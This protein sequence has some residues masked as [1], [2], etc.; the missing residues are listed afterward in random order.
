MRTAD[1]KSMANKDLNM[2]LYNTLKPEFLYV[3]LVLMAEWLRGRITPFFVDII[4]FC[5]AANAEELFDNFI[6]KLISGDEN[7]LD[8]IARISRD[9]EIIETVQ[10]K[11]EYYISMAMNFKDDRVFS[12]DEYQIIIEKIEASRN[13]WLDVVSS[14]K[15]EPEDNFVNGKY[16]PKPK[17]GIRSRGK[18]IKIS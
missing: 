9:R 17:I 12:D 14:G 16:C 5:D 8:L 7:A 6:N 10:I 4:N 15:I 1:N 3:K 11:Y 2:L 18:A 13:F